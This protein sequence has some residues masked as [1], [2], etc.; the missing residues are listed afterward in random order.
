MYKNCS[1]IGTDQNGSVGVYSRYSFSRAIDANCTN[2]DGEVAAVNLAL[3]E[4]GKRKD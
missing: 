1:V 3:T 2:Y 4:A